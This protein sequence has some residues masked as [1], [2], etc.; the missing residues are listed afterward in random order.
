[1]FKK[2]NIYKLQLGEELSNAPYPYDYWAV[3][4]STH[5]INGQ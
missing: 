3:D 5:K 4:T 1:M 2:I